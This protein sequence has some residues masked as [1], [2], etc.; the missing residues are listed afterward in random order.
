MVESAPKVG[1]T[2]LRDHRRHRFDDEGAKFDAQDFGAFL[3]R[4]LLKWANLH[5]SL[6][7]H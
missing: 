5:K 7:T 1:R 4:D 2:A 3:Q 6:G